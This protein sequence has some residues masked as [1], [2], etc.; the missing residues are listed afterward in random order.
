MHVILPL[1]VVGATLHRGTSKLN[2]HGG[3]GQD[4]ML[5]LAHDAVLDGWQRARDITGREQDFFRIRDDVAA[6]DRRWR[7]S[8]RSDLLL[9]RGLP[10]AEARSLRT[11]YESELAP[12][13]VAF[14]DASHRKEQMRSRLGYALAVVFGLVALVA[15]GAGLFASRQQ[16]IAEQN[17]EQAFVTQ[18]RFLADLANQRT[19]DGEAG[20]GILLGLAALPDSRD[21]A[22]SCARRVRPDCW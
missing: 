1:M 9:S 14:I 13:I 7:G 12:E 21:E 6:A 4:T 17:L 20:T 8:Q 2:W 15:V 19:G 11:T 3:E 5:R 10:L 18:S 16:G 22:S